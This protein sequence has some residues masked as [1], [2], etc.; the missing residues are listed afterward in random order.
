M[1]LALGSAVSAEWLPK[2]TAHYVAQLLVVWKIGFGYLL[3]G[4]QQT[5]QQL[6][7]AYGGKLR[8]GMFVVI[9]MLVL[10][11]WINGLVAQSEPWL[12]VLFF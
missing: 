4:S 2:T 11:W 5:A 10:N 8:N 7:E 9:A 3:F 6:I 1:G 12:R